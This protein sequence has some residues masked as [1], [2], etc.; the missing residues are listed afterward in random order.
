MIG[1]A[2]DDGD[3]A[4]FR[5]FEAEAVVAMRLAQRRGHL[6]RLEPMLKH[7]RV[8]RVDRLAIRRIEYHADQSRLGHLADRHNMMEGAGAAQPM[9]AVARAGRREV[10]HLGKKS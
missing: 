5:V 2:A 7:L 4:V 8:Q 3:V 6:D 10:P 9:H 1:N